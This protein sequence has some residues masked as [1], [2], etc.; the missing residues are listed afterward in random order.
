MLA[1]SL[2]LLAACG[3]RNGPAPGA[4]PPVVSAAD[5]VP[6]AETEPAAATPPVCPPPSELPAS[7]CIVAGEGVRLTLLAVR[8]DAVAPFLVDVEDVSAE[9]IPARSA[10][11]VPVRVRGRLA[12]EATG[13]GIALH[14]TATTETGNGMVTLTESSRLLRPTVADGGVA[15]EVA[16]A[17]TV[18]VVPVVVPCAA[19]AI[20][21]PFRFIWNDPQVVPSDPVLLPRVQPLVLRERPDDGW[22]LEVRY[23]EP[24]WLPFA[25]RETQGE[26]TRVEMLWTDGA[27]LRGW[28]RTAD[29]EQAT[30]GGYGGDPGGGELRG[31]GHRGCGGPG[32]YCGP[33]DIAP[34]TPVYA[35]HGLGRWA[36]VIDGRGADVMLQDGE[37]FAELRELPGIEDHDAGGQL[38]HAWVPASAVTPTPD[39]E[40]EPA[41][42]PPVAE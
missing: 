17:D 21:V 9:V 25:A 19:L 13:Q 36:E 35:D 34:G 10:D 22:T 37:A 39:A 5:V 8:P 30:A 24:V 31:H 27:G 23:D 7:A 12:F 15:V 20:D 40:P 11:C 41:A 33:A 4:E 2:L 32:L 28:A 38:G 26:L 6:V 18:T 14:P 1:V 3:P 29:L 16:I 42:A